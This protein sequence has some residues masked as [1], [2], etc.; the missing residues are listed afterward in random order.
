MTK[1]NTVNRLIFSWISNFVNCGMNPVHR[2][3]CQRTQEVKKKYYA[4]V[5][6]KTLTKCRMDD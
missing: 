5:D 3:L 2:F 6:V 1:L 4:H